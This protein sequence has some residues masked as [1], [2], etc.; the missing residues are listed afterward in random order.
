[1]CVLTSSVL[2]SRDGVPYCERDYQIQFGIQCEACQKFITGKVLEVWVISHF[3]PSPNPLLPPP[4]DA[5]SGSD[6][7]I[8]TGVTLQKTRT[9]ESAYIWSRF[10]W[11]SLFFNLL[12]QLFDSLSR[13]NA[14]KALSTVVH[15]VTWKSFNV[16][17]DVVV[18]SLFSH[19]SAKNGKFLCSP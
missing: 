11:K 3:H 19:P 8:M 4:T 10:K 15:D 12:C 1:M 17:N 14:L 18:Q 6:A 5:V 9:K 2:S 16:Q 7:F 13:L